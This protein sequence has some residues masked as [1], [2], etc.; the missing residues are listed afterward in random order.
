LALRLVFEDPT[1][2]PP[3]NIAFSKNAFLLPA[4][5]GWTHAVFSVGLSDLQAG[6]G[7]VG[8]A[9]MNTTAIRLYHSDTA[10]FPNPVAPIAA[11]VAQ[12]GVDN[13]QAGGGTASG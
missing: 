9:L 5:G 10:N 3:T 7:D 11:I 2:G 6:L 8:T 12:L 13:I 4:G 1:I